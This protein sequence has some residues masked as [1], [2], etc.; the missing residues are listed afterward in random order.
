MLISILIPTII[1]VLLSLLLWCLTNKIHNQYGKGR[2]VS[3]KT[4]GLTA[5][6][7]SLIW[8]SLLF[9]GYQYGRWKY[10]VKHVEIEDDRIPSSFDG[11]KIVHISDLHLEGFYDN[12]SILDTLIHAVNSQNPDLI[13]FTGDLVSYDDTAAKHFLQKLSVLSAKDGIISILGNHDYGIYRKDLDSISQEKIRNRV[14]NIEQNLLQWH[15]LLND[16]III[17]RESDSICVIG[18]ENQ[19]CGLLQRVRRGDLHKACQDV[20]Q[21][22]KILLTHDPSHWDAEVVDNT[23]IALTLSGHTHAMQCKIFDFSPG[24][25]FYKRC[26]SLYEEGKHKL[27]VNIGLGELIPFRIGA[28]PE[29]TTI[30]L[31]KI[32]R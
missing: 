17:K 23:D 16:N 27:Y 13:C 31:H 2:R 6:L 5:L 1:F 20:K 19:A 7:F 30:T 26:H 18:T 21:E 11:Y 4:F 15:L 10:E 28:I 12:P 22:F 24:E 9:Y 32:E 14:I 8:Y 29:I 25:I 3:Y